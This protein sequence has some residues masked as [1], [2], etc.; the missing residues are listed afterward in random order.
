MMDTHQLDA[1]VA[2]T[3]GPAALGDPVYG[4]ASPGTGGSSALAAV[5]GYP[6]ITVPTAQVKS[7]PLG[8]SFF[9][10]AWTEA[11]LLALAADFERRTNARRE[12]KLLPTIEIDQR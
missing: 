2:L 7:L 11:R 9:G 5:A 10:R 1:L 6:S 8:I 3:T 4:G 12:P